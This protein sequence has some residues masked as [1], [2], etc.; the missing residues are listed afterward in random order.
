MQLPV[1]LRRFLLQSMC[2]TGL[3]VGTELVCRLLL[4]WPYPY[5]YWAMPPQELFGDFHNYVTKFG[6]FHSPAFFL[7]PPLTYPAPAVALYRLFVLDG[8]RHVRT[9]VGLYVGF[10][11]L[12]FVGGTVM[13]AKSLVRRGLDVGSARMFAGA[14]LVLSF[15]V[16]FE[17][18]QGNIEAM[19]WVLV[20]LGLWAVWTDRWWWAAGLLG[21]AG[22]M[23]LFPLIL[24][25]LFV[26]GRRYRELGAAVATAGVVT[27]VSLWLVCPEMAESVRGTMA[28]MGALHG[29]MISLRSINMGFDHGLLS[30]I[31]SLL[32]AT[33]A[34]ATMELVVRGYVVLAAVAGVALY[35]GRIRHLPMANQMICLGVASVLLPPVSFDYTLIHLGTA[36]VLC[37]LAAVE[38]DRSWGLAAALGLLAFLLSF[39]SELIW[40]GV[41]VAGQLKAVGLMGLLGV[42]M[43][44]PMGLTALP[45]L[46]SR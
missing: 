18:H 14:A 25:A 42:G 46:R 41:R 2:W 43:W 33:M 35:V 39:Q 29:Q 40:Q 3:C 11:L 8:G 12:T 30:L 20:S 24:L 45:R 7:G 9:A 37:S 4:R 36:L 23:K 21:A 38:G 17:L 44:W 16:W 27:G 10:A 15:P 26:S 6:F 19:V 5:N 32:P 22:A 34:A 31:K 1:L 13:F 28:A